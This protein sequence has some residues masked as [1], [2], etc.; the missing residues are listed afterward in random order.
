MTRIALVEDNQRLAA[1]VLQALG[2]A[3]IES[4]LFPGIET[5]WAAA[6]QPGYGL[7]VID[8]GCLRIVHPCDVQ[9]DKTIVTS[10]FARIAQ[11]CENP[12][13]YS[14]RNWLPKTKFD[15]FK[16]DE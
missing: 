12:G 5:A 15:L 9:F 11:R 8:R 7:F 2:A 4:D 6:Q 1:F 10:N 13:L 16:L 14:S 3:G